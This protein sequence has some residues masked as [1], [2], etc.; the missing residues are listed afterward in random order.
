MDTFKVIGGGGR[1]L[2]PR[3]KLHPGHVIQQEI[4]ARG[5]KKSAFAEMLGLSPSQLSELLHAKRHVSE[6]LALRLE[7]V[8]G[9][10]ADYWM[11]IQTKYNLE[12]KRMQY[13]EHQPQLSMAKEDVA[14]YN[15][16]EKIDKESKVLV[17][18]DK[19]IRRIWHEN[20]WYFNLVDVIEILSES[21]QPTVYWSKTKK[22]MLK[23]E[24]IDQLFPIWKQLKFEASN[25][26]FYTMD[27]AN[28]EGVLRIIMS[29]SS[30]KAEPFKLW[31]AEVSKQ[32]LDETQDPEL[33]F[34]RMREIYKAKGN[35]RDHMTPLELIF[36]ALGE[37]A[38]RQVALRDDV[39]G[40][41]ENLD[42]A[43]EGGEAAGEA[44]ERFEKRIGQK[45]VSENNFLNASAQPPKI[46]KP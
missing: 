29:I 10:D 45:V 22:K 4:E 25:G 8:L 17:F 32:T 3:I 24:G 5:L 7:N 13:K 2:K 27:A 30:P 11:R 33:G 38:T 19:P 20:D 14:P 26:K 15:K 41:N 35:L 28:T 6:D 9:I 46:E 44:R 40:Y 12:E 43:H 39:Q 37:E 36:T 21:P 34:E 42:A 23:E 1:E 18:H 16:G 31:M